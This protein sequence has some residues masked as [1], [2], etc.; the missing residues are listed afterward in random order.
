MLNETI[1][2]L[3]KQKGFTQEELA[4]RLHVVRQTISKWENGTSV[5][6]ADALQKLAEVLEVSVQDLLGGTIPA[7]NNQ[8]ELIEQ[9]ARINEQM[10][11]RNRRASIIWKTIIYIIVILVLSSFI[12][13]T[14]FRFNTSSGVSHIS[15]DNTV[16]QGSVSDEP[17]ASDQK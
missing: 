11:I 12:G 1:R 5:P 8:N 7:E 16:I 13:C 6:D 10:A 2:T 14:F 15:S 4:I 3:R 9:L 17:E